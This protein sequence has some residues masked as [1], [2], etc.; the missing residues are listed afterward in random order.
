MRLLGEEIL[1]AA[2]NSCEAGPLMLVHEDRDWYSILI[3]DGGAVMGV[4]D[5]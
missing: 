5:W 2:D 4:I 1:V 3:D